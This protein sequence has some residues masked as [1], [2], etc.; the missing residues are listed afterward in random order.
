MIKRFSQKNLHFLS[1]FW[2]AIKI[3]DLFYPPVWILQSLDPKYSIKKFKESKVKPSMVYC[4]HIWVGAPSCYLELLYKLQ[5][6]I[7][8][9]VGPSLPV[10]LEPLAQRQNKT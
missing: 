3:L 8:R 10:S 9:T 2:F 6:Q 1:L 5:K 7:C 4:C